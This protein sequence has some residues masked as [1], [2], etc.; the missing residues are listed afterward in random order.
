MMPTGVNARMRA[1]CSVQL[2]GPQAHRIKEML[3]LRIELTEN[4]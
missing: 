3:R 4:I 1:G 2:N